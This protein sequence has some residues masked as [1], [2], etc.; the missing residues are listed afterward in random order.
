[1]IMMDI[2]YLSYY[3]CPLMRIS[4]FILLVDETKISSKTMI[5]IG[6]LSRGLPSPPVPLISILKT[7]YCSEGDL[8]IL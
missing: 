3:V 8:V 6:Y 4:S 1:M 2:I 5:S 7:E